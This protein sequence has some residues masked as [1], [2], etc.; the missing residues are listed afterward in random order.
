MYTV[1]KKITVHAGDKGRYL[2]V[3]F[4]VKPGVHSLHLV[5]EYEYHFP[6]CVIQPALYGPNG[7]RGSCAL[8]KDGCTVSEEFATPGFLPGPVEPGEWRVVLAVASLDQPEKEVSIE[9]T[10]EE[11]AP[12]WLKADLHLHSHHSDGGF[13]PDEVNQLCRDAGL[14]VIALTDHNSFTQNIFQK[15]FAGLMRLPGFEWTTRLGHANFIG[16]ER[17]ADDFQAETPEEAKQIIQTAH[18]R[19]A[20]IVLNHPGDPLGGWKV[21][22]DIAFDAYEVWNGPWRD[23]ND[24]SLSLWQGMLSEGKKIPAVGGSDT[25]KAIPQTRH[26]CPCNHI[27]T[28]RRGAADVIAAIRAGRTYMTDCPQGPSLSFSL[29]GAFLGDTI[30]AKQENELAYELKGLQPGD[31][32]RLI[33]EQGLVKRLFAS[34]PTEIRCFHVADALFYRLEVWRKKGGKFAPVLLSN[35]IYLDFSDQHA[36]E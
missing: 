12:C 22:Y 4:S 23:T 9:I 5:C 19:G 15:T 35:P 10:M 24:N 7:F 1:N 27:Y 28:Q 33:N 14:D 6:K 13:T 17:P 16:L 18:D 36:S 3:P 2:T 32:I 11:D 34:M 31:E 21:G 25:H 29:N 20:L 8:L 30:A 26:G